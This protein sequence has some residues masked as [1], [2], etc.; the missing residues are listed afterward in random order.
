MF[1][2]FVSLLGKQYSSLERNLIKICSQMFYD[3]DILEEKVLLEWA[4]KVSKKYVSRDLSQEIHTKAEPFIKWLKEAEEEDDTD[5][6]EEDDAEDDL[7]V[8]HVKFIYAKRRTEQRIV[9]FKKKII[10]RI[11]RRSF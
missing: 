3:A 4:G 9:T 11:L 5:S 8:R 10:T 2:G 1:G 6:A 7:E